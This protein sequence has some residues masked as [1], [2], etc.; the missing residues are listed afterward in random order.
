MNYD[1]IKLLNLEQ[2]NIKIKS[3]E[4]IKKDNKIYCYIT[5]DRTNTKCPLCNNDEI[6]VHDYVSKKIVHSIS[7]NN[8][9]YIIYRARRYKCKCCNSTFY[10]H[11]PFA[12]KYNQCSTYT[13]FKVL[14]ELKSHTKTFTDVAKDLF[15]ST[16]EV[17]NI[18]D[19]Y[20]DYHRS[21]LPEAICFDEVYRSKRM[22]Y[23]YAFVML[24]FFKS[25]I[26]DIYPTRHKYQL[27]SYISNIPKIERDSVKYIIIDMWDTYRDLADIYFKNAK[28]AVDSFH[29]I[30]HLNEAM[31]S[32][33]LRV[34]RK[35]D[36]NTKSLQA[37]DI[38]YYMLKKFHYFFV[39][40]YENIYNG[41]IEIRKMRT[42]WTKDE[43]RKY[44]L[45]IDEDLAYAYYLKEE[46]RE[47][48]KNAEY[49]TCDEE[50]EELIEKFRNSHIYE[51]REFGKI[52]ANWKQA[53][54]NSF[55]RV[56]GKRLSNGPI[57]G[58][59]SRIKTIIKASNGIKNFSRFRN[60]VI[61]GINKDVPTKYIGK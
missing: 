59:N 24:D 47:F 2:F 32:V 4:T 25:K 40:N 60:R 38:Y 7:N 30:K 13:V 54:K 22:D 10:E 16:Q 14:D 44:L 23:K 51:Y 26:I 6:I 1:I 45:S 55:I 56:N 21:I 52:L 28:I 33:R 35:Y 20:V 48:S 31:I 42:H 15:I 27:S 57:E 37:N 43:I 5:L 49:E 9:C 53:I 34:M 50:F 18:F 17:I 41:P 36:K 19:D 39:K 29:V 3:L 61:Y 58:A 46:Y 11:N 12:K 8:K